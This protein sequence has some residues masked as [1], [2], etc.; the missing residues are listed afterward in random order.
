[1]IHSEPGM[2][3]SGLGALLAI[4]SIVTARA[5]LD[6]TR[7]SIVVV[8]C[9]AAA[10]A[11]R[12]APSEP[13]T[14]RV[15]VDVV[16]IDVVVTDRKGGVARDEAHTAGRFRTPQ[17]DVPGRLMCSSNSPTNDARSRSKSLR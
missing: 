11:A 16:S 9:T 13:P 6:S 1:M 15:A 4:G 14:F 12:Q 7:V 3:A 17:M 8:A 10:V 5:H 2:A